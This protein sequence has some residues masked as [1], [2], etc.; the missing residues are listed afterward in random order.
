MGL[1]VTRGNAQGELLAADVN[2][3]QSSCAVSNILG[4]YRTLRGNGDV[5]V[6]RSLHSN[7][8]GIVVIG[9][10]AHGNSHISASDVH[11]AG[12]IA[13]L[14]GLQ[15]GLIAI[16]SLSQGDAHCNRSGHAFQINVKVTLY[17][18]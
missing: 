18:I 7:I 13:Y 3:I 16:G 9:I 12:V 15:N 6:S 11:N 8:N 1:A 4:S 14:N 10:H 17:T 2:V 5:S